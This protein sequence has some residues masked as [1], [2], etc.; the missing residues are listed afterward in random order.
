[1]KFVKQELYVLKLKEY[2]LAIFQDI[3]YLVAAYKRS[4]L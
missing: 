1:M 4:M 3:T 2:H